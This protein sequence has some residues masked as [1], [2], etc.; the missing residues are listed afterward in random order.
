MGATDPASLCGKKMGET[1]TR[2]PKRMVGNHLVYH[3]PDLVL[4][5][6]QKG[7]HIFFYVD[8]DNKHI[9][10]YLVVFDNMVKRDVT[11]RSHIA[12]ETINGKPAPQS[13]YLDAL[14]GRFEVV[15]E[16]KIVTC[17]PRT[18]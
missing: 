4:V 7:R 11:P 2:L 6:R 14:R 9:E 18:V 15:V 3:G 16:P 12:I 8:I 10:Q 5:S 17:Y 1:A 13:P